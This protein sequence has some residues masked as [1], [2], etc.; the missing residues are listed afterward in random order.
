[1]KS[2]KIII[3]NP[4]KDKDFVNLRL[5]KTR[6]GM[7]K[8]RKIFWPENKPKPDVAATTFISVKRYNG[9]QVGVSVFHEDQFIA[10][11]IAHEATHIA[12]WYWKTYIKKKMQHINYVRNEEKFCDLLGWIIHNI[13]YEI[14]K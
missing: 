6:Q 1:M 9:T 7:I 12:I 11:L 14:N 2:Y 4:K 8:A 3:G 5:Y 10:G 13:H